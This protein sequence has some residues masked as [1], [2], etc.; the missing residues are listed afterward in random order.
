MNLVDSIL[1][2]MFGRPK[3]ILGKLGGII[4][5]R[6]NREFA[7]LVIG[8]LDIQGNANFVE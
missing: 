3:G 7:Y 1:M 8:R 4:L 5:A 6:T 2:Q